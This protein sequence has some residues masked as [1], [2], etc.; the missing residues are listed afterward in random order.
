M[1][2]IHE[3]ERAPQPLTDHAVVV[4]VFGLCTE[5]RRRGRLAVCWCQ[6]DIC[7]DCLDE[8]YLACEATRALLRGLLP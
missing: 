6:R 1:G 8:H 4:G 3:C 2:T 5:C 7:I